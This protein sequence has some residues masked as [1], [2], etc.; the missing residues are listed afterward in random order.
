[1]KKTYYT[2]G[3]NE[4]RFLPDDP[5]P[6]GWYK[7]RLK[8]PVTT[9]D[10]IWINN[11]KEE[12][13]IHKNETIP[14]EWSKGRLKSHLNIEKARQTKLEKGYKHYTDGINDFI[15]G[16]DA[17]IPCHLIPG[18]PK[19][20][21][22]SKNKLSI[23][24][25]GLHHTEESK[26]KISA[27]SNNNRKKAFQTIIKIYGSLDVYYAQ[28]HSKG[29][30]SKLRNN[31]FNT[32]KPEIEMYNQLCECYGKDNVLRHYKDNNRY[33]FYCDFY[34]KPLDKFIELNLHWTHGFQP[35]IE[36]DDFCQKQLEIWQEKAKTSQFYK[37]AIYT[38]TV[39]DVK[40]QRIAKENNLNY[41][42][43]Y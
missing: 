33:P 9:K 13:F 16:K 34:I 5:I 3:I 30:K 18:R 38:W 42:V 31:T 7:G 6:L 28:L 19:M 15:F 27:H 4:K 12:K 43:I 41:E 39:L 1:M 26:R 40:K 10:H 29:N 8:S 14:S 2:N 32:S 37:N 36:S 24:H 25:K 11:G 17:I 20:T 21:E 23:A 22:E 35:F